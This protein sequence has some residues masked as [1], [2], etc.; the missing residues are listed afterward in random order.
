MKKRKILGKPTKRT[1]QFFIGR[2][3]IKYR[4]YPHYHIQKG[5]TYRIPLLLKQSIDNEI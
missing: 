4:H 1:K 3:V 2:L 5:A